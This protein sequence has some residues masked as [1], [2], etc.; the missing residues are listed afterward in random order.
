MAFSEHQAL[1]NY[2]DVLKPLPNDLFRNAAW[3]KALDRKSEDIKDDLYNIQATLIGT[4][5]DGEAAKVSPNDLKEIRT[6]QTDTYN[7]C[8]EKLQLAE[9]AKEIIMGFK[10]RLEEEI[11][12]LEQEMGPEGIAQAEA[13]EEGQQQRPGEK[14]VQPD[15]KRQRASYDA[16]SMAT[17]STGENEGDD[18]DEEFE[19]GDGET[20]ME[21]IGSM[22]IG[23]G[24]SS[25]TVVAPPASSYPPPY[26]KVNKQGEQL[27]CLCR[28]VSYGQMIGCDNELCQ[29][30]W[31][32]FHCVGIKVQLKGN[33]KWYCA[34]CAAERKAKGV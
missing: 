2:L 29:Y 12:R 30:E 25:Q 20:E 11:Q 3:I 19:F 15:K 26:P 23:I 9:Q 17:G 28:Q 24:G 7:L 32:H 18:L 33:E 34:V 21:G 10:D 5:N 8:Q 1:E 13:A 6:K 4:A 27:F 31:F 22:G 14:K 16:T